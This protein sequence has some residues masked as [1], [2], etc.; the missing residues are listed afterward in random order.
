MEPVSVGVIGCGVI[1]HSHARA[2]SE[3]PHVKLVAV[4]D[5]IE[6]R[7]LE[8]A[9]R[10]GVPR[11]YREGL[12][13]LDDP[14]VEA[15]VLALPANGR[16]ALALKAF[17]R[18]IHVLTEKPVAMNA[19]DLEEMISARG[20]VVAACCS[21]RYRL[22]PSAELVTRFIA[23]GALG[24]LRVVHCRAISAA[25]L[26]PTSPPPTWRLR[27][28]ENG[29]GILMNWGCYD[30]D[31]LLGITGWSLTPRLVL[32]QTWRLAPHLAERAAPDSDA[33]THVSALIRCEGGAV[34]SYERAEF[35]A[36]QTENAWKIVGSRGALHLRMIA[37]GEKRIAYDSSESTTGM[38]PQVLW[39]GMEDPEPLHV[40]PVRDFAA[41]IREGR[42]PKTTLEQALI[43]QKISDA[44]YASANRGMAVAI[45]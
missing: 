32:G 33:E 45:R 42:P 38:T 15:V 20:L 7:A 13:L 34:I 10:Y 27:R 5:L 12:D 14:S 19:G 41:A 26:P 24:D 21:S 11:R 40:G 39:E 3:A 28:R 43:V 8:M 44:I 4:A 16:K 1:G 18:G 30:L 2:A 37:D 9:D 29:G 17:G 6:E 25:G 22:L 35:A 23:T 31:F 36:A